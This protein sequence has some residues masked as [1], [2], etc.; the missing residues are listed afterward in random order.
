MRD[1]TEI[2]FI[3]DKEK[4]LTRLLYEWKISQVERERESNQVA[5]ILDSLEVQILRRY[6]G[7]KHLRVLRKPSPLIV[8][9]FFLA[10]M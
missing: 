2:C 8:Q 6:G 3:I 1:W 10:N 7:G 5:N 9:T 4:G